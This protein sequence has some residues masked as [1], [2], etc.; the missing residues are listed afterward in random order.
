MAS[1]LL[2]FIALSATF[3][4]SAVVSKDGPARLPS[5]FN[6]CHRDSP[7]IDTC[8]LTSLKKIQPYLVKGIPA[9]DLPPIDP[10]RV[11][12]TL[13]EY[14]NGQVHTKVGIRDYSFYG[15]RDL[16]F[17]NV[18]AY[19]DDPD[20]FRLD[21]DVFIPRIKCDGKYKM[22]GQFIKSEFGGKGIFNV[23]MSNIKATWSFTG[24]QH[25]V[26]GVQ[27]MKIKHLDMEP[28]VGDMKVYAS[29]LFSGNE[30]LSRT[31][32]RLFNQNW[33]LV[34]KELLPYVKREWDKIMTELANRVFMRVPYDDIFPL[35]AS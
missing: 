24:S 6:V 2:V 32:L 33:R 19:L 28:V 18:R 21:I 27:Y 29:N 31:A 23:S 7:D 34:Y 15:L 1:L 30:A 17:Q 3:V 4:S 8:L 35:S 16:Q 10:F 11:E 9:L 5:F 12:E 20:D 14:H 26:N 22:Q 13:L 25:I